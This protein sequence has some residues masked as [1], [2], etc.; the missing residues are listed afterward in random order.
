MSGFSAELLE[1]AARER[2]V[3]LTTY[4]RKTGNPHQVTIWIWGDD[5][6]LFITSGQ[7]LVRDWPQNLLATG[8]AVLRIGDLKVPVAARHLADPAEARSLR[9]LITRKYGV[10]VSGSDGEP[11][12]P[13][14]Q[15]TFELLPGGATA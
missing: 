6:R 15:A 10:T 9:R 11:P 5:Q 7:G 8:R 1:A 3:E 12:T 2:E 13:A 14:E 4:G